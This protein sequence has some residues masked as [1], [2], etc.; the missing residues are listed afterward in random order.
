MGAAL[1]EASTA[2]HR[3]PLHAARPS[4][5]SAPLHSC[6]RLLPNTPAHSQEQQ[7]SP[8]WSGVEAATGGPAL[9][10]D[11]ALAAAAASVAASC[12]QAGSGEEDEEQAQ[13]SA[14][15]HAMV[16]AHGQGA[17]PCTLQ[18]PLELEDPLAQVCDSAR[19]ATCRGAGRVCVRR[20]ERL[21]QAHALQDM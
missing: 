20:G 2:V 4:F 18:D 5:S 10:R 3:L 1:R 21:L 9:A 16:E 17:E 6:P 15:F 7:Y 11:P 14:R 19:A 12:P 13:L 8:P